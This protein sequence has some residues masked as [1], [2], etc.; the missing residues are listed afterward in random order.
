MPIFIAAL[1]YKVGI[2]AGMIPNHQDLLPIYF[3]GDVLSA[4]GL[5]LIMTWLYNFLLKFRQPWEAFLLSSLPF[6]GSF[7]FVFTGTFFSHVMSGA[8]LVLAWLAYRDK[9]W[10]I[11]GIWSG[12]AFLSEFL[13]ILIPMV[14]AAQ[15]LLKEGWKPTAKF[16]ASLVPFGLFIL[17]Y[18]YVI[19]GD[20]FTM[21][22]KY[23]DNSKDLYG[24]GVPNADVMFEL[25]IPDYRGLLFYMPVCIFLLHRIIKTKKIGLWHFLQ[26][27]VFMP[28]LIY[29]LAFSSFHDWW[30]GWSYGPRQL[31]PMAMLLVV[32]GIAGIKSVS[33]NRLLFYGLTTIGLAMALM[34]KV[35]VIY[36]LPTDEKHPFFAII[37]KKFI[38]QDF[39]N[40]H[41][42]HYLFDANAPFSLLV[43]LLLFIG[44][45]FL[46]FLKP[47]TFQTVKRN[48]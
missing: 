24:L 22:Y 3:I 42:M 33:Y 4:L 38:D 8:L 13:L 26:H 27:P 25:L 40:Q 37:C 5:A 48:E 18:N 39:N 7:V 23:T 31:I 16:A 36:S 28:C 1:I 19:G 46:L 29:F 12:L 11:A 47:Q 21:L 32:Y 10:I 30:G 34:A 15:L 45:T 2:M 6:Y 41:L 43:W 14:W 35:T 9:K 17:L 20:A 44:L